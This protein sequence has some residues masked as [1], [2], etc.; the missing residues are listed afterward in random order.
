[1]S[2]SAHLNLVV[3]HAND[4]ARCLPFYEALGLAFTEEQHGDGPLHY[5]AMLGDTLLEIYPRTGNIDYPRIGLVVPDL[6][7]CLARLQG[8]ETSC[9]LETDDSNYVVVVD[10]EGRRVELKSPVHVDRCN[11]DGTD[12]EFRSD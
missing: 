6:K 7:G 11:V 8:L 3:L 5:S 2:S 9:I 4:P 1:M 10:P 12:R